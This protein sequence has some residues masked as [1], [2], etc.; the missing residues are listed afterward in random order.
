MWKPLFL[1]V[2]ASLLAPAALADHA[3]P[4][5]AKAPP[6]M[7]SVQL[8]LLRRGPKWTPEQTPA[9]A[10]LQR[11]HIAHLTRMG[12][13]GK[14]VV[15]GPF[16]EQDDQ[17]LRGVCIYRV[18]S[19]AEARRLAEQDPMVKAGRLRVEAMRWW[20]EKGY[21]TFPRAPAP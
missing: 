2:S 8:V 19:V 7:E 6:N 10:E 14:M 17:G 15:A 18:E 13:E 20:F 4:P 3:A 21:M 5:P 16:D 12:Q 9:V 1:A 11:Q